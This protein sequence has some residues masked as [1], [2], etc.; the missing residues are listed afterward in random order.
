MKKAAPQYQQSSPRKANPS[1]H[2]AA[3]EQHT[4]VAAGA[5]NEGGVMNM[6]F[7]PGDDPLATPNLDSPPGHCAEELPPDGERGNAEH[8]DGLGQYDERLLPE[9]DPGSEPPTTGANDDPFADEPDTV[10]ANP[11]RLPADKPLAD[12]AGTDNAATIY[13][14]G[15]P[16][17][18]TRLGMF[19]QQIERMRGTMEPTRPAAN[20]TPPIRFRAAGELQVKPI[21]W[22]VDGYVEEDALVVMF[23]PPGE[24]KS[25]IALDLSCCIA[26]GFDFHGQ[27]VQQGAV[28]YIAGE[29]HNGI[30]RRLESWAKHNGTSLTGAALF[31]SEGATD[32]ANATNAVRVAEA[33]QSLADAT[34]KHPALIVIDTLARNF[35]GDENS[36][37]DVGNF[38]RHVDTH[39][40]H[41]WNATTLI[42]HHSGKDGGRGAR[43]SSALKGAAD[44]E[45]EVGRNAEDKI[46]RLTPRKMKDAEQPAP[47]AFELVGIS[48]LD[49]AGQPVG[50]AAL[51]AI[52][53]TA[54]TS[55]ASTGMGKNQ[56][57]ALAELNGMHNEISDRL[58]SQGREDHPVHIL[59]SDWRQ[60]CEASGM[61]P[62]RFNEARDGLLKRGVISLSGPHVLLNA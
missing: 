25:F 38:V 32:L 33:V 31:V 1:T 48:I 50:G 8:E 46:I 35:G 40:R 55:P 61:Q 62:K 21:A 20:A 29:G 9:A 2:T 30:A 27:T 24:G 36:A 57:A 44:A 22:L 51:S 23:G 58:A 37:T 10:T 41:K 49:T 5:A 12:E 7:E 42:V 17:P 16:P 28:F 15:P 52:E 34:G 53:H 18:A 26:T 54:P 56:Q 39:L 60:R 4:A 6:P 11:G 45:Y 59:T 19:D 47:L 43:G 3:Q 14:F 13:D